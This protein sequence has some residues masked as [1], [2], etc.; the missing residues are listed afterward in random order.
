M[1]KLSALFLAIILVV[2]MLAACTTPGGA[3]GESTPQN[4]NGDSTPAPGGN[5]GEGGE[6]DEVSEY[7]KVGLPEGLNFS[8]DT[9]YIACWNSEQ[10]EY[11]VDTEDLDGD[12]INDAIYKRNLYTEQL[13]G[14]ELEFL[15]IAGTGNVSEQVSWCDEASKMMKDPNT[16]LDILC[17]R[18]ICIRKRG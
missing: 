13:L 2:S 4:G 1:K 18:S 5:E 9:V 11:D 17:N 12:P 7:A 10:P 16:P 15:P 14:I 6:E 3:G 8:G